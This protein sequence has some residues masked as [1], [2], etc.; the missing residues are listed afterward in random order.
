LFALAQEPEGRSLYR[1]FVLRLAEGGL[2]R[3]FLQ[4]PVLAR[5]LGRISILWVEANAEF[6]GRL[7]AD[8]PELEHLFGD[9]GEELGD[10][11]EI[12]PSLSDPHRGRAASWR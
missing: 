8:M 3:L 12:E 5:R 10:G 6:L 9:G 4:Y 11:V 7:E 1:Q 2:A